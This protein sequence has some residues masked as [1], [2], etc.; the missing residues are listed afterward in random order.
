MVGFNIDTFRAHINADGIQRTS[1]FMV[2]FPLPIGLLGSRNFESLV[3]T[4]RVVEYWCEGAH[5]P[6]V[7]L[8]T[9]D[10]L[11]YG[12]GPIDKSVTAP[13]FN[14]M[15]LSFI[16][17]GRAAIWSMLHQWMTMTVNFDARQSIQTASGEVNSKSMFP[18]EL[19]YKSE[20]VSDLT[21]TTFRDDGEPSLVVV[22]REAFPV[23]LGDVPM[24]WGDTNTI[25]KL[26]AVFSFTD[27]YNFNTLA[28]DPAPL[29]DPRPF[30][31]ITREPV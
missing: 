3:S 15:P 16:F 4:D 14:E 5:I 20:Y 30:R 28:V 27:W 7:T 24:N 1:K 18:Y 29:N 17:D 10:N 12:Y 2:Q 23:M 25:A 11:R 9:R 8:A 21:I 31:Q 22:L 26:P 6:G 19:A 13:R